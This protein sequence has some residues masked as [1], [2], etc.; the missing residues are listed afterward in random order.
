[1][2]WYFSAASSKKKDRLSGPI[3]QSED[4][5]IETGSDQE[6]GEVKSRKEKAKAKE[7]TKAARNRRESERMKSDD[8]LVIKLLGLLLSFLLKNWKQFHWIEFLD[9]SQ[10]FGNVI[11]CPHI[12]RKSLQE[13]F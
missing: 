4:S 1:M 3:D 5:D 8:R 13:I 11:L 12:I 2:F 6:D 10:I 9:I 7:R